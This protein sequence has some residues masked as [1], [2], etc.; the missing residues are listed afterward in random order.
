MHAIYMVLFISALTIATL[1]TM[2]PSGSIDAGDATGNFLTYRDAVMTYAET[3]TLVAG[4]IPS[5]SLSLPSSWLPASAWSNQVVGNIVYIWGEL[6]LEGKR[7]LED[8]TYCSQAF[9]Y[10]QGLA[11]Q[12]IC[13]GTAGPVLPVSL[14]NKTVVSAIEVH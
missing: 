11:T 4:T 5:A 10:S 1:A 8:M 6:S 3:H 13:T 7:K 14:T 12:A 9:F 2:S